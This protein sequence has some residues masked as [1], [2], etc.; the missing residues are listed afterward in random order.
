M[1]VRIAPNMAEAMLLIKQEGIAGEK[2][3][4]VT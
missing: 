3:E 4:M 2:I 1:H